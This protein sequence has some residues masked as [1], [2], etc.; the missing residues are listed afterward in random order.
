ML[1]L[2]LA[3]ITTTRRHVAD[4]LVTAPAI[5]ARLDS[6]AP[7]SKWVFEV[8]RA[9]PGARPPERSRSVTEGVG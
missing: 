7:A 9:W 8:N 4:F 1:D 6:P 5:T 3:K 2:P